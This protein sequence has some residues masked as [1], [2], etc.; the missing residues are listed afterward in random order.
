[1]SYFAVA[2]VALHCINHNYFTPFFTFISRFL[3]NHLT[4]KP[5]ATNK[6]TLFIILK[7]KF[8]FL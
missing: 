5:L 2:N 6:L 4:I 1:V 8:E 3:L 7:S